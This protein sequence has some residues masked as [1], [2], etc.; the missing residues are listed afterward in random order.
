MYDRRSKKH[1][2]CKIIFLINKNWWNNEVTF[3]SNHVLFSNEEKTTG[4]IGVTSVC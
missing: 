2:N 4:M 1:W 3:D